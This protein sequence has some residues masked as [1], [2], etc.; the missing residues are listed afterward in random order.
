MSTVK[1]NTYLSKSLYM[2]GLQCVKA[3]YLQKYHSDLRAPITESQQMLFD[4]G[5]D[6]N[7]CARRLFHSGV[8]L[9]NERFSIPY[10]IRATETEIRRGTPAI[11]EG[12]FSFAEVFTRVDILTFRNGQHNIYEVKSTTEIKGEHLDDVAFQYYVLTRA[13]VKVASASVVYINKA[14]VR[15]GEIDPDKLFTIEDITATVKERLDYVAAEVENMK[16]ALT[17]KIPAIDIGEY[18]EKP[19][20][21]EFKTHCWRHLPKPSIFDIRGRG[22]KKFKLYRN[23]IIRFEDIDV[24]TLPINQKIQVTATLNQDNFINKLA[25]RMFLKTLHYPLA[26]LDFETFNHPIPYYSGCRAYQQIPFQYSIHVIPRVGAAPLHYEF[27]AESGIDSR[28][29]L[30]EALIAA[31]PA[32]SCVV[33]YNKV[34]EIGV[35]GS[36]I[37][38]FPEYADEIQAI[39]DN[40]IDLM[41]PFKQKD[42]YYWTMNGSYS[43][44]AV[45]PALLPAMGYSGLEIGNGN[46]AMSAFFRMNELSD[47]DGIDRI[48]LALL[49]YC[50]LDTWGMVKI[51]EELNRIAGMNRN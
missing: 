30:V 24:E 2:K 38:W 37:E 6:V 45:L 11:F 32:N 21:C 28:R 43:M 27:L 20:V 35:L 26:Y 48:R 7:V 34:F 25:V 9:N 3:L 23:G 41:E 36:C 1:T 13:G 4:N 17:G 44:K 18:C 49:R 10:Q 29:Q 22:V 19:Y 51:V 15:N 33:T 50:E 12:S 47:A 39:I 16:V 46:M 42:I 8:L 31:I 5:A 40:I 14:Y